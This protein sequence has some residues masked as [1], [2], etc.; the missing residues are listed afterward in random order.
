[1]SIITVFISARSRAFQAA[2]SQRDIYPHSTIKFGHV[3]V[4]VGG[5]YN[6]RTHM[7]TCDDYNLYLFYVTISSYHMH[8]YR[9]VCYKIVQDGSTIVLGFSGLATGSVGTHFAM[10]RCRP[11]SHI[12][13]KQGDYQPGW[14]QGM[15]EHHSQFGGFQIA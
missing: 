10:I 15:W 6:P 11:G 8:G 13:V 14:K 1:M 5:R 7:F 3:K 4:N 9:S 12:W 2:G